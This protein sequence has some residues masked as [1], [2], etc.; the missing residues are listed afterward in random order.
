MKNKNEKQYTLDVVDAP[1]DD[2][3]YPCVNICSN[4]DTVEAINDVV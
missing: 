4:G 2:E 1:E 3:Y